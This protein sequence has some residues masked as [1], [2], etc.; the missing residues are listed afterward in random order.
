MMA[1]HWGRMAV[2]RQGR[3][4]QELLSSFLCSSF[5]CLQSYRGGGV[6]LRLSEGR[7]HPRY[8]LAVTI[9]SLDTSTISIWYCLK[10]NLFL[11]SLWCWAQETFSPH[12]LHSTNIHSMLIAKSG[13]FWMCRLSF[14]VT[15]ATICFRRLQKGRIPAT[16]VARL[17]ETFN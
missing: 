3:I 8:H 12:W 17:P 14:L 13:S 11:V 5:C 7:W 4:L 1:L 16:S 10:W 9:S 15:K 6:L 2:S